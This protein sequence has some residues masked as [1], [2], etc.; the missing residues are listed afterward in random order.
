MFYIQ[1]YICRYE[2][3]CV[4]SSKP[5]EKVPP[6]PLAICDSGLGEFPA[7]APPYSVYFPAKS[8]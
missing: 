7:L 2:Y 8:M 1:K 3:L 6:P 5:K 4:E